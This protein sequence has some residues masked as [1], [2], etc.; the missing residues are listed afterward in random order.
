MRKPTVGQA[1]VLAAID[2]RREA[3]LLDLRE[4]F[5]QLML[6]AVERVIRSL[7]R[8]E[9]VALVGNDEL[10]LIVRRRLPFAAGRKGRV[11]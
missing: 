5:P 3:T 11:Q 4:D 8:L 1:A 2:D 6:R 7:E 10:A 9:P